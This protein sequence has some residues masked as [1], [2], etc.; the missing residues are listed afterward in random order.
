MCSGLEKNDSNR[1]IYVNSF[2]SGEWHYL[3]KIRR[4]R[5]CGLA[6]GRVGLVGESVSMGVGVSGRDKQ[7]R[8]G[9]VNL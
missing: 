8:S 6:G 9:G 3:R 1:V 4:I 7:S 5:R 2:S